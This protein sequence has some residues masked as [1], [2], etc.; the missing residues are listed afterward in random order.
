MI[1]DCHPVT[2]PSLSIVSTPSA[3]FKDNT[4]KTQVTTT[5]PPNNPSIVKSNNLTAA[6]DSSVNPV[7]LVTSSFATAETEENIIDPTPSVTIHPPSDSKF[8]PNLL[9]QKPSEQPSKDF[10]GILVMIRK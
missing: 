1:L 8:T 3:T 2:D 10:F 6:T 9:I 5:N 7:H 4:I